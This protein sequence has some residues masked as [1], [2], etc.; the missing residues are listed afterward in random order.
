[1]KQC[2]ACSKTNPADAV[3]CY[4]D[5]RNLSHDNHEGPLR[6]GSLPFPMPFCF[7]DGTGCS[8]FN[9][10]ALACDERWNEARSLLSEGIWPAFFA[11]IGRLDLAAVAKQAVKEPDP[12]VGLS[13][14]LEKFPADPDALRLPRLGVQSAEENLGPLAP[15]A[16]HK[17]EVVIKNQ[18]MLVL[19]GMIIT[20]C[21]W[22]V[23]GDRPGPSEKMFQTRNIFSIPVRIQGSKLRAG[24]KPLEGEIVID[25][26]GGTVTVPVRVNVPIQPFPKG[27]YANDSLAGASSPHELALKAKAHPQEAAV[28][29]EQGAVKAWYASNGWTYPIEGTHGSGK[30]A[31]QQFFEALGLT[32][33]P[34]LEIDTPSLVVKGQPGRRLTRHV[35]ISSKEPKPV[36]AQAW[37]TQDWVKV[38]TCKSRG[39]IVTIPVEIVVPPYPGETIQT[40]LTIQGN[41]K[42]RFD[43][44]VTISVAAAETSA[45]QDDEP[46]PRGP[47]GWILAGVAALVLLVAAGIVLVVM[48][49]QSEEPRTPPVVQIQAPPPPPMMKGEAWWDGIPDSAIPASLVALKQSAP[50]EQTLFEDLGVKNDPQRT[51]AYQ[52][53]LGK[54]PELVRNRDARDPL[55]QLLAD[56]YAFEPAEANATGVRRWLVSQIPAEGAEFRPQDKGADVERSF[57]A[58]QV[59]IAALTHNKI[60]LERLKTLAQDFEVALGFSIN[61]GASAAQLRVQAEKTLAVRSY[62]N[63]LP[64]ALKSAEHALLVRAWLI[65]KVPHYLSPAYREKIDVDLIAVSLSTGSNAWPSLEPILR[66]CLQSSEVTTNLKIVD[67]YERAD[68]ALGARMEPVLASR[69]KVAGDA[70][71]S[72]VAKVATLRNIVVGG[73]GAGKIIDRPGQ[74]QKLVRGA[75][76]AAK[77]AQKQELPLLQDT[78]RLAH[79]STL[80]CAFSQKDTGL[81]L[82]DQLAAKVPTIDES[83]DK[84]SSAAAENTKQP[85]AQ[86]TQA[87]AGP[88]MSVGAQAKI[89]RD[90]LTATSERDTSTGSFR[91]AH[92]FALKANQTYVIDLSSS[93]FEAYVRV[94]DSRGQTLVQDDAGAVGRNAHLVWVAPA[95]ENYRVVATTFVAGGTGAYTLQIQQQ[96]GNLAGR[97]NV[98]L[99][100]FGGLGGPG[101]GFPG[102]FPRGRPFLPGMMLGPPGLMPPQGQQ[103]GNANANSSNSQ[104]N[105]TDLANLDSKQ[106]TVRIGAFKNIADSVPD[107]LQ[108][109]YAQRIARYLL[110]IQQ[111]NELNDVSAKLKSFANCRNL[112]LALADNAGKEETL[113]KTAEA[114]VGA[115]LGQSLQFSQDANWPLACKKLLLQQALEMTGSKQHGAEQAADLLRDLYKVQGIALGIPAED[116]L[117]L[118]RPSQVLQTLVKQIAARESGPRP[119]SA[120]SPGREDQEYLDQ[121][122]RHLQVAQYLADNDLEHTVLLQRIWLKVLAIRLE[123]QTPGRAEAMRHLHAELIEQD[124][125]SPGALDQLRGGEEKLLR[126]WALALDVK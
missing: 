21:D 112:V 31:V 80:A 57:W 30:G 54:L 120:P 44:P 43:V 34:R 69:W 8:N 72:K 16:D 126:L 7:S 9:Q 36:Y 66:S 6:I 41:G 10:L 97:G 12:D 20:A 122:G 67:L 19:R 110:S 55:A 121:L 82:F 94:E 39:N 125:R 61:A 2:P 81:P 87:A 37:S 59:G 53:L 26:N 115:V 60:P 117:P 118:T 111:P 92:L 84:S 119:A 23:I 83:G 58:L 86:P 46:T 107:D 63:T 29:F 95:S 100:G 124:R 52:K 85:A 113:P 76:A 28:L 105:A 96:G 77:G 88:A 104:V 4:Y 98:G 123:Q 65:D 18:G 109:R 42:Q 116:F 5:G 102:L 101:F 68:P 93:A 91:K 64:T 49:R 56:C 22:L 103:Q 1:M 51:E 89:I 73:P 45:D 32:K 50:Q 47:L 24:R 70:A 99:G 15:G 75:F 74:L 38:G 11:A 33:A 62:R 17:F 35:T 27:V 25:T 90:K 71:L 48:N 79:A 14:L 78:V 40:A 106:T 3:F 13:Q 108:P 114:I